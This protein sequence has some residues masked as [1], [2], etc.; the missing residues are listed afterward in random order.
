MSREQIDQEGSVNIMMG[1]ES[2]GDFRHGIEKNIRW[3]E[4]D[5]DT[6]SSVHCRNNNCNVMM[7]DS[8]K[9]G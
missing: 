9:G 8:N 5:S 2:Q 7:S 6:L 4:S 1:H 3:S